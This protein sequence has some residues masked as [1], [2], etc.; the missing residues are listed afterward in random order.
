M[1]DPG[2][3]ELERLPTGTVL[4]MPGRGELFVRDSGGDGPTVVL[5]HGWLFSADLNW[6]LSYTPLTEAGYRVVAIDHRGHGRG[7]RSLR[8]FRLDDCA[9]DAAAVVRALDCAPV[10]AV[11]YSMGGP[12][13]SLLARRHP[14]LVSGLVFCA[15]SMHWQEPRMRRFWRTMG[16]LEV[17]LAL[18]PV[19]W[20][21]RALVRLGLP[22]SET[23]DWVA[24]ELSRGDPRDMAEAGRELGRFDSRPWLGALGV[25]AAVVVTSRDRSVPPRAQRELAAAA[26]A[27]MFDVPADHFA[28]SEATE[29]FNAALLQALDALPAARRPGADAATIP[30]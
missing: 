22:D 13:A 27:P 17:L 16:A 2:L 1:S 5:L 8:R 6:G 10:I 20:W 23:T 29:R 15:T 26:H 19:S 12:I 18:A 28:V 9:D 3:E 21:R 30:A 25:P 14:G 7:I 11:G 4:H 24:A